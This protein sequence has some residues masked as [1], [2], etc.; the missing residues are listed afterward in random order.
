VKQVSRARGTLATTCTRNPGSCR[1]T[2]AHEGDRKV[3]RGAAGIYTE[4]DAHVR[5]NA[6]GTLI[7]DAKRSLSMEGI[8]G[9]ESGHPSRGGCGN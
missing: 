1:C 4:G 9:Q 3:A 8:R 7:A 5:E 6:C 2:Y